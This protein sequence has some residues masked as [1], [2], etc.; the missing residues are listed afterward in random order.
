[1]KRATPTRII[2]IDFGMKRIGIAYSDERKIIAF[3]LMTLEAEKKLEKTLQILLDQLQKHQSELGYEMEEIVVG[4]PLMM[5]GKQ[6]LIGDEVNHFVDQLGK[7]T[8]TPIITWDER[9]TSV[10][11]ERA[12]MES[13]MTRKKRTQFVD[14]VSAIIILQSYLDSKSLPFSDGF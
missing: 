11:A 7:A 8:P 13:T 12:L 1:M 14:R 9:L 2:G 5:S 6:G 4:L 10:Q 3:P